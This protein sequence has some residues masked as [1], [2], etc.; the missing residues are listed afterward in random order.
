ML[1]VQAACQIGLLFESLAPFRVLFRSGAY[2]FN[3]VALFFAFSLRKQP[4]HPAFWVGIFIVVWQSLQIIHP[5]TNTALSAIASVGLAV[6]VI[7]PLFWVP[8]I[9]ITP[10]VVRA[11]ILA[12]WGF[13][14]LST[15]FGILQVYFPGQYQPTVSQAVKESMWGGENLRVSLAG[16]EE[17]YRPMG[18][19]D[20]PG[21]SATAGLYAFMFGLGLFAISRNVFTATIGFL[22][23]PCGL[24]CIYLSQVRV[25]LVLGVIIAIMYTTL[26]LASRRFN[27]AV[28]TAFIVPA[29]VAGAFVWA[30]AMGGE[31]T[32][33]R[34]QTLI[35]ENPDQVYY[36]NRGHFLEETLESHLPDYPLGAGLGRWGMVNTYFGDRTL[37]GSFYLWAEIQWT[38]W[39]FDGGILLMLAYPFAMGI[40]TLATARVAFNPDYGDISNWAL[41]IVAYNLAIFALT[42]SYSPFVGQQGMEFWMLNAMIW[43]AAQQLKRRQPWLVG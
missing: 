16:G 6:A 22:S 3:I 18:L 33:N 38:S 24:F 5:N 12:F 42:F 39:I 1:G 34:F 41:L 9:E 8:R 2:G 11:A 37:E 31:S 14:C 7:A 26:L 23:L 19:T 32:V 15:F 28:R 35:Q 13:H 4:H 43:T 29:V 10:D 20:I 25:T 21:G 36:K 17:I 30:E 27:S 40:A